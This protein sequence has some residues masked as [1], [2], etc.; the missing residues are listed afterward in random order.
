MLQV[1]HSKVLVSTLL[2]EKI[3]D[4][5]RKPTVLLRCVLYNHYL[6]FTSVNQYCHDY[7]FLVTQKHSS[8]R[9]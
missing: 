6:M 4:H 5:L 3:N 1:P 2:K 7:L 9:V 8:L